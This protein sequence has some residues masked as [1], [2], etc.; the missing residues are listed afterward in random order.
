MPARCFALALMF[1]L[2]AAPTGWA[3]EPAG[4]TVVLQLPPSMSPEDVRR[5]IADLA[6]KGAPPAANLPDPP[7]PRSCLKSLLKRFCRPVVAVS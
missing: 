6:A 4:T 5:L 7:A 3:G 1:L 2:C